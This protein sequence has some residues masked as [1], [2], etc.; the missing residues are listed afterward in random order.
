M[1]Y[2]ASHSRRGSRGMAIIGVLF[3]I[4]ITSFLLM[5]VGTFV[6]SNQTRVKVDSDYAKAMD[7]AEAGIDYEFKKIS[8]DVTTADQYPGTATT[9]GQGSFT[10]YCANTDGT[11][12]WTPGN[13]AII[14][15]TG[16][17]NGVSRTVQVS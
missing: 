5:G 7:V 9:F 2:P 6:V 13:F 10:V 8:T 14:V 17:V 15:C 11:T 1:Q 3:F 4:L 12:P 16:T